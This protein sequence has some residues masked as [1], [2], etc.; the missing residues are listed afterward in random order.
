MEMK[1]VKYFLLSGIVSLYATSINATGFF[2]SIKL[3]TNTIKEGARE[4]AENLKQKA[5]TLA[6]QG[7]STF[8]KASNTAL[9]SAKQ[10]VIATKTAFNNVKL[11]A[12]NA[13]LE[14]ETNASNAFVAIKLTAAEK[15]VNATKLLLIEA[16]KHKEATAAEVL[17]ARNEVNAEKNTLQTISQQIATQQTT[18]SSTIFSDTT[19]KG[20]NS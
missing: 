18:T 12:Q 17:V 19:V 15:Y 3:A 8:N 6:V 13:K 20:C 9:E 7:L 1:K 11:Q 4:S 10:Q 14:F 2:D 16:E 5:L